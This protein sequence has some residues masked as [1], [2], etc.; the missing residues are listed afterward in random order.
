MPS[1]QSPTTF[2]CFGR[3]PTEL[4]LQIWKY[5]RPDP[6]VVRVSRSKN[7]L[8]IPD[9]L[10]D[11]TNPIIEVPDKTI[12]DHFCRINY[13]KTP[14]PAMLHACTESRQVAL[15]WYKLD[16]QS[17]NA[18]PRVYFDFDA[19]YLYIGCDECT[20]YSWCDD[21]A[22][23]FHDAVKRL[24]VRW[25]ASYGTP[26][27]RLNR[28]FRGVKEI[29]LFDPST[30]PLKLE[31]QLSHLEKTTRPF[32]WNEGKALY[33]VFL[34]EK[35]VLDELYH[36][37]WNLE[38]LNISPEMKEALIRIKERSPGP[39]RPEKIARVELAVTPETSKIYGFMEKKWSNI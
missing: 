17:I 14:I 10:K 39:L 24:L 34:E 20:D 21:C 6:R 29:L 36:A 13:S 9:W 16:F 30:D 28:Y 12:I 26:F 27:V 31:V 38:D 19:D 22:G 35:D 5:A 25:P 7:S 11:R 1:P 23:G 37:S 8:D 32:N 3:L 33:D 4:R 2:T 15:G 18:K